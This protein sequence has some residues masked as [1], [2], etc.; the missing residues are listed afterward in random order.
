MI[1]H[2]PPPPLSTP[3]LEW[4][5]SHSPWTYPT[6]HQRPESM[7]VALL[8]CRP[9]FEYVCPGTRP[10]LCVLQVSLPSSTRLSWGVSQWGLSALQDTLSS[11]G[12]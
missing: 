11:E 9:W 10:L 12:T 7:R 5:L 8:L 2:M 4:A 1:S 6:Y 3:P